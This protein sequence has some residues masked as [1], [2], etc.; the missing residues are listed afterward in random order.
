MKNQ[1]K[2]LR[3]YLKE[4]AIILVILMIFVAIWNFL[5]KFFKFFFKHI[6][7]IIRK[8]KPLLNVVREN[9]QQEWVSF[10]S[11]YNYY[12][13]FNYYF[14]LLLTILIFGVCLLLLENN[15]SKSIITL[16]TFGKNDI[17]IFSVLY[18]LYLIFIFFLFSIHRIVPTQK[19]HNQPSWVMYY[20][21]SLILAPITS[22]F[23]YNILQG[24]NFIQHF[25]IISINQ[26]IRQIL[27]V[28]HLFTKYYIFNFDLILRVLV[29]ILVLIIYMIIPAKKISKNDYKFAPGAVGLDQD[30]RGFKVSVRNN[31]E[32]ILNLDEHV[33]VVVLNGDMGYGKSSYARMLVESFDEKKLLYT[34]ISLTETNQAKDF[35]SLFAE[36]WTS[37]LK[38]RY[39]KLDGIQ[40]AEVMRSIMR[41]TGHGLLAA[42]TLFLI[43]INKGLLMTKSKIADKNYSL[44]LKEKF[45]ESRVADL[46]GNIT[47]IC[48]D[49]W[50]IMI[51]EIE[52]A[53]LEEV[54]RL[55]EVIERFKY[56][57][58]TGLPVKLV[59]ILCISD[60]DFINTLT[61][62]ENGIVEARLIKLFLIDDR[63]KNITLR[64]FLPPVPYEIKTNYTIDK[65]Y[66][67]LD[68]EGF[69]NE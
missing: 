21:Y 68:K 63:N 10:Y 13:N 4:A 12:F 39:P 53:K 18:F 2:I 28:T 67:V 7:K 36:R 50:I 32:A 6:K 23:L 19:I 52:R 20:S 37:T 1:N 45:V 49:Q 40:G 55:V 35:S 42:I 11:K 9:I 59:F 57:G 17:F 51:D 47:N 54:Y 5:K 65:I 8:I 26:N 61:R 24:S 30:Q 48:E 14:F 33:N 3:Q 69:I 34:Y 60:K 22:Y 44:N 41:E 58:R 15:L 16:P 46:F 43:N 27:H 66:D 62:F 56:E 31:S 29:S 25:Q 64:L 38:E